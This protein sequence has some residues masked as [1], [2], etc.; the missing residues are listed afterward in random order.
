[1]EIA[2]LETGYPI[3][4][5][6]CWSLFR[7]RDG[8]VLKVFLAAMES[9]KREVKD[10]KTVMFWESRRQIVLFSLL[11]SLGVGFLEDIQCSALP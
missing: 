5:R 4:K 7:M 11:S 6:K 2:I 8:E 1:M 9:V 3:W 10:A